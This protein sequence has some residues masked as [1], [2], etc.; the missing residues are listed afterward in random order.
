MD[1]F[2]LYKIPMGLWCLAGH[3]GRI[4]DYYLNFKSAIR[5]MDILI[6]QSK[7]DRLMEV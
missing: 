6:L 4:Y 3:S 5:G 7:L 1:K 2:K